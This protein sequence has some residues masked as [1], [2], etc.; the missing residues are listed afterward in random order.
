MITPIRLST[1]EYEDRPL[2][3]WVLDWIRY[4]FASFAVGKRVTLAI[5]LERMAA[6]YCCRCPLSWHE[7]LAWSAFVGEGL[8]QFTYEPT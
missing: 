1:A 5:H 8:C 2:G 3:K 4:C 7:Q 6:R